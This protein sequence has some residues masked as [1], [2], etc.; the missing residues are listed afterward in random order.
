MGIDDVEVI[1]FV[2]DAPNRRLDGLRKQQRGD[3]HPD[4]GNQWVARVLYLDAEPGFPSGHSGEAAI[5]SDSA[6]A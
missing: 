2:N 5:V 4:F 6:N 1:A 3:A